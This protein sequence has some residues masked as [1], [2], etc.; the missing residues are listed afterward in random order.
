M[1]EL[2]RALR[3]LLHTWMKS[4][5]PE[6]YIHTIAVV[7]SILFLCAR[8]RSHNSVALQKEL[9]H[10]ERSCIHVCRCMCVE[11]ANPRHV[12][13]VE[14]VPWS[15]RVGAMCACTEEPGTSASGCSSPSLSLGAPAMTRHAMRVSSCSVQCAGACRPGARP[16]I[17]TCGSSGMAPG[18][19]HCLGWSTQDS[20]VLFFVKEAH[21]WDCFADGACGR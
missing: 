11:L 19:C 9:E 13:A 6:S 20:R 8:H 5:H 3:K 21:G 1:Q 12:S 7:R 14:Q 17:H 4:A 2:V 18:C 15:S 16:F 10:T